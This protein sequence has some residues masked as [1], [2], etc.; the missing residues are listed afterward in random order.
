M[1]ATKKFRLPQAPI[2]STNF[3]TAFKDR[4]EESA[5]T[6]WDRFTVQPQDSPRTA[7]LKIAAGVGVGIALLV[8]SPLIVLGLIIGLIAAA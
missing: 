5:P 3:R 4:A 8:I 1:A 2:P 6:F 7:A